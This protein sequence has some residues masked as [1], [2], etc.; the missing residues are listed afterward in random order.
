MLALIPIAG[1]AQMTALAHVDGD[2]SRLSDT[3]DGV[4]LTLHLSQPVPWRVF[5]LDDP[6]R[7]VVDLGEAIWPA[8][9]PGSS[10]VVLD[11][12]LGSAGAGWSRLVLD[13]DAPLA[14]SRAGLAT[15]TEDGSAILRLLLTPV[16]LDA[17]RLTAAGGVTP[18]SENPA[19][20]P[21]P[22][23][24]LHVM[25]DPGHGGIDPGAE[26]GGLNE[27]DLLLGFARELREE[28]LRAGGF[29]V[30]LTRDEDV[31]V[32]LETRITLARS[33]RA[34]VFLS[35]HADALPEDAGNASG[36]TVYTLNEDAT[37][38]ASQRLAE[39]HEKSDLIAGGAIA[40]EGD[41]I[42]LVLM[43]LARTETEPRTMAL[44]DALVGGIRASVGAVNSRPR[45]SA[46]F[47]VL[48]APDIPSVLVEL[49]FLS[50]KRDR[51]RLTD[52]DWRARM[53]RGIRDGL[54]DWVEADRIHAASLRKRAR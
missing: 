39:R 51:E 53:A 47:S 36:A 34:D 30:S 23:A 42:A 20:A 28:L 33:A 11:T 52:P 9:I 45:R 48:K 35:L 37:D 1:Q 15:E 29:K 21:D 46:A 32:P 5:A 40:P 6:M 8:A 12:R 22:N 10:A 38:R 3:G 13:L 4:A 17:F 54:R 19:V 24:P 31:F 43:D 18:L 50:S 41:E 2:K 14:I 49:G 26:A 16:N 27:A 7:I 25:I 44:A